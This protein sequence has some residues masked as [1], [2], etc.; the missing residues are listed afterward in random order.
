MLFDTEVEREKSTPTLSRP[1][2]ENVRRAWGED[3]T[4]D[5]VSWLTSVLE[6]NLTASCW[7]FTLRS[8]S[9]CVRPAAGEWLDV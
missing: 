1:I 8:D 9:S 3:I 7:S 5:L 2:P 4:A 6:N